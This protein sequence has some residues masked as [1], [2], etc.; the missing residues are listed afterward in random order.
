MGN[1]GLGILSILAI[2]CFLIFLL[3]FTSL[4]LFG[5]TDEFGISKQIM[6][7]SLLL[8]LLLLFIFSMI[9]VWTNVII[10][11]GK[12][13]KGKKTNKKSDAK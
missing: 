11:G 10:E 9:W 7:S 8:L 3:S 6:Y 13:P 2:F 4:Y 1:I 5:I 12:K